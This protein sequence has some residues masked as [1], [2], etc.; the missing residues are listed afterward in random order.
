MFRA[1]QNDKNRLDIELSGN[2]DS[3]DM[4]IALDELV[5]KSKGIENAPPQRLR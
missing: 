4:K 3:D 2:P 1:T 5:T